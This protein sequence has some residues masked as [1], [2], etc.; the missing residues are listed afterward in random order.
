[1]PHIHVPLCFQPNTVVDLGGP[2]L[3]LLPP[4]LFSTFATLHHLAPF[5]LNEAVTSP[6]VASMAPSVTG[7]TVAATTA[8]P[9]QRPADVDLSEVSSV[10]D[11]EEVRR[12][13]D[14]VDMEGIVE[15]AKS[16]KPTDEKLDGKWL[17]F[18]SGLTVRG[19]C[20]F[21]CS[22][23]ASPLCFS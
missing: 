10:E 15:T 17:W 19:E 18:R 2:A 8:M 14:D 13:L 9:F 21:N 1:M 12:D 11:D 3:T 7:P 6:V 5:V 22:G 16:E 20:F 4:P 23:I